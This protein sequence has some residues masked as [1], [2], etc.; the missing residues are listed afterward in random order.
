WLTP[1]T[2]LEQR[3]REDR[4]L[5]D[6]DDLDLAWSSTRD[7]GDPRAIS[8][9]PLSYPDVLDRA[10]ELDRGAAV[11]WEIYQ[12]GPA[13]PLTAFRALTTVIYAEANGLTPVLA[14]RS[15]LLDQAA[16]VLDRPDTTL[17]AMWCG[18]R[19][20]RT[21]AERLDA[22][23]R[24]QALA[25]E[26]VPADSPWP[27]DM[28]PY[29][30]D[31]IACTL[32]A[33]IDPPRARD[34]A[35]RCWRSPGAGPFEVANYGSM[36]HRTG[37]HEQAIE[38]LRPLVTQGVPRQDLVLVQWGACTAAFALLALG[39]TDDAIAAVEPWRAEIG[40][41]NWPNEKRR[42]LMVRAWALLQ[43]GKIER[44]ADLV[45]AH[46][47]LAVL[48]VP[49][50]QVLQE[51][52]ERLAGRLSDL[53]RLPDLIDECRPHRYL[54]PG[55]WLCLAVE[56]ALR[57]DGAERAT[58]LDEIMAERRGLYLSFGYQEDLDQ[59]LAAD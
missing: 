42:H 25:A 8:S 24:A 45:A 3:E 43:Q 37:L 47:P 1:R 44:A 6:L 20:Q 40:R 12:A 51:R 34:A 57:V 22:A 32:L 54:S 11:A 21:A 5:A 30:A 56:Q 41:R 46:L 58:L 4:V 19:R 18:F 52:T 27:P 9:F 14:G 10:S 29:L 33:A 28:V 31:D 16:A 38:V 35:E 49:V 15:E 7:A 17:F 55:S 50:V 59:L 39:R 48:D 53:A 23:A 36:L 13:D 26:P 2:R